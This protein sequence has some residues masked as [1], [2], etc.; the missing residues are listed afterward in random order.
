MNPSISL[1]VLQYNYNFNHFFVLLFCLQIGEVQIFDCVN[2][3]GSESD[4]MMKDFIVLFSHKFFSVN[5]FLGEIL[6]CVLEMYQIN[7]KMMIICT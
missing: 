6:T 1:D 5:L 4:I 3:V 2:L 7:A